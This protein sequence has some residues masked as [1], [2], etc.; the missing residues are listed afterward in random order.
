MERLKKQINRL[1]M[2]ND[3]GCGA[4]GVKMKLNG[5]TASKVNPKRDRLAFVIRNFAILMP[6]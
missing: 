2:F 1:R 3:R 4:S 6:R 5:V